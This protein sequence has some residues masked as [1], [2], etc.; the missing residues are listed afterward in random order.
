ME[1]ADPKQ[2]TY[3]FGSFILDPE[4]K[5]LLVNGEPIHLSAKEFNTLLLFVQNNGRA[6]SKEEMMSVIWEDTTVEEGNLAKQISRLRK[7]FDN[8]GGDFIETIPKHGYRFTADLKL[9]ERDPRQP[10]IVEKRTVKRLTVAVEDS[11][12]PELLALP[13]ASSRPHWMIPLGVAAAI[14]LASTLAWW[15]WPQTKAN[16]GKTSVSSVAVLPLQPLSGDEDSRELGLGLTD[17]LITKIGSL[18][19]VIVP[20]LSAVAT[21][22]SDPLET[23]RRLN[24]DA[25]LVG[26]IQKADGR[27]RVNAQLIRTDSGEQIWANRFEQP[28][29]GLFALQDALSESIAQAL[30]FELTKSDNDLLAH[31]GTQNADAYE[32]YLRGRYFETQNTSDGLTRSIELYQ[33]AIALDPGFADAYAGVA[34]SMLILYN[35]GLR[36]A[37]ESIPVARQAAGR[38]LEL[39]PELSSAHTSIALVQ[40][41][42]DRNWP[43]A[44]TSL[45][46]AIELNPNNADAYLRYGYFLINVGQFDGALAKL[47]KARELNPVSPIIKTDIGLADL[48]ARRYPQAIEQLERTAVEYP[49][50]ALAQWLLGTSYE[51]NGEPDKAFDANMKAL[52]VEGANALADRLSTIRRSDGLEAANR[53]WLDEMTRSRQTEPA[54]TAAIDIAMRAATLQDQEQTIFWLQTAADENEPT[55]FGIKYLSKFDFVREDPRFQEIVTKAAL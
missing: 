4:E 21:N 42:A 1:V 40:F 50:F 41:F 37:A 25:V 32:R 27:L 20:P 3:E 16:S 51:V 29:A 39:N 8:A 36:S 53:A 33:Q 38:A 2:V 17:E 49:Q 6:L 11:P 54:K 45:R 35:F 48:C 28:T 26:T 9:A 46:T 10:L 44:E 30:A 15:F 5:S 34:D 23:G 19:R 24:V 22:G 18:K 7:V 14:V 55:L 52:E 31:R 13:P 12:E 47:E 43:Q